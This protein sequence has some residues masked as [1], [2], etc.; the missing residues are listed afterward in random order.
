MKWFR[1]FLHQR[2]RREKVVGSASKGGLVR[3]TL[4]RAVLVVSTLLAISETPCIAQTRVRSVEELR[5]ALAPGDLI[6]IVSADGQPIA[7]R[8]IRLGGADLDLRVVDEQT[9][10]RAPRNVTMPLEA[11]QSL[12]RRRDSSRNGAAI[13]AGVGAGFGGAMFA[14]AFIV[15][16]NEMDEWAP[17]YVGAATV[18]AG[19]GALIGWALDATKSKPHIVFELSSRGK[20]KVSVQPVYLPGRGI[21][22]AVSF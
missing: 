6:T 9:S 13:G 11:I 4:G 19:I 21:A 5:N 7:G 20:A 10:E 15:D 16:R 22:L 1:A 8:L 17:L 3:F 14:Y 12:E 18:Y 2:G